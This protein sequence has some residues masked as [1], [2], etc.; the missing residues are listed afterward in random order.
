MITDLNTILAPRMFIAAAAIATVLAAAMPA[1]A[2]AHPKKQMAH[3]HIFGR[4]VLAAQNQYRDTAPYRS[5]A[6]RFV[7]R[8]NPN[9]DAWLCKT[10]PAFCPDYHGENGL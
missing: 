1:A 5:E 6:Y 8:N 4:H 10:V 9:D 2:F 7:D 3:R